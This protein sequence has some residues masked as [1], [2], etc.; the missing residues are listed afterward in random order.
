VGPDELKGNLPVT[1][2][3]VLQEGQQQHLQQLG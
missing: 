3:E 2:R 1:R